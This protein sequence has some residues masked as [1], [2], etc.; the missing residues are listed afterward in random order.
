MTL[1]KN[2]LR[3]STDLPAL[4]RLLASKTIAFLDPWG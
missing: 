1:N 4:I 3:H 2:S